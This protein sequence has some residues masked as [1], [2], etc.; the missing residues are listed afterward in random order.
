MEAATRPNADRLFAAIGEDDVATVEAL[1]EVEPALLEARSAG[2][3][4]PVT[5]AVYGGA[6][7]V[8][9]ALAARGAEPDIFEAAAL[10]DI[11]RLGVLLQQ[12]PELVLAYSGDGWTPLHLAGHF[13]RTT[14][15]ALLLA[16][17]A[18]LGARSHN[19]NGNTALH[20]ALAGG[21]DETA[22]FLVER[23][24]DVTAADAA[25]YTPLHLAAPRGNLALVR[26][27][28]AAGADP[29]ARTEAGQTPLDLASAQGQTAVADLLHS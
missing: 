25:G 28:L 16:H 29:N 14:A 2:G 21:Q 5:A 24:A 26:V 8:L 22:L 23:G 11:A 9:Q 10:G 20:A 12:Q 6:A 7:G 17:G 19:R 4:G 13:G 18:A 15:A 1:L 27:L 3:L